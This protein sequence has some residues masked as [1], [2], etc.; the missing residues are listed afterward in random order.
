MPDGTVHAILQQSGYL[1]YLHPAQG[2]LW[3]VTDTGLRAGDRVDAVLGETGTPEAMT[4]IDGEVHRITL[5]DGV[6]QS[7]R[8][9]LP[10]SGS[11]A[12][13]YA[14]GGWP[15]AISAEPHAVGVSRVTNGVWTRYLYGVLA[16]GPFEAVTLRNAG[17]VLYSVG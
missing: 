14:G 9:G 2:G 10:A 6:W 17:T 1:Y 13:V 12:A 16:T 4:V 5:V 7:Q 8:T 11:V 3:D 15:I